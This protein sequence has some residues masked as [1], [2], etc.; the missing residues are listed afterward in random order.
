MAEKAYQN[1]LTQSAENLEISAAK[2][3]ELEREITVLKQE[4]EKDKKQA[5]SDIEQLALNKDEEI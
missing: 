4:H 2:V 5:V 1:Q 3:A